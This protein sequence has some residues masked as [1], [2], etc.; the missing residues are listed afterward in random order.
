M[1]MN[2]YEVWVCDQARTVD[3]EHRIWVR[4][5]FGF[6]AQRWAESQG[7]RVMCLQVTSGVPAAATV[8]T[9]GDCLARAAAGAE[10]GT[11]QS[12]TC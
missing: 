10:P 9:L 2:V 11:G 1:A 6:E 8:N 7:W 5:T 12:R 4:C 3:S